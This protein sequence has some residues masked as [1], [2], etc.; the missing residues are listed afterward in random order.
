MKPTLMKLQQ[1]NLL[2]FKQIKIIAFTVSCLLLY[3][4]YAHFSILEKKIATQTIETQKIAEYDKDYQQLKPILTKWNTVF[5]PYTDVNDMYSLIL[6]LKIPE[7]I[8]ENISTFTILG[9]DTFKTNGQ[10][11]G[12]L[13]IRMGSGGQQGLVFSAKTMPELM[14]FLNILKARQDIVFTEIEL[15]ADKDVPTMILKEFALL[16]RK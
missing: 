3:F 5:T 8:N 4:S 13:A 9:V 12:L 1:L 6:L 15:K 14:N 10:D 11:I 7:T 2:S 16:I